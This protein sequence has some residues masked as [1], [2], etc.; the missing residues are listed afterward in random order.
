[1]EEYGMK[2]EMVAGAMCRIVSLTEIHYRQGIAAWTMT[3]LSRR[4][5]RQQ[6]VL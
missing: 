6:D 5:V 4:T 2:Y 1:M 3:A